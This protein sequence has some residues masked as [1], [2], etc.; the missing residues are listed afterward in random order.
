M[1][2]NG[3]SISEWTDDDLSSTEHEGVK[4][5]DFSLRHI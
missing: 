1:L 3:K 5:S 4:K 2:L